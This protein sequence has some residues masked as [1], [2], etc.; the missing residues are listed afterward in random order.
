MNWVDAFFFIRVIKQALRSSG[1]NAKEKHVVDISKCA[2]FLLEAAKKCDAVFGVTQKSTLHTVRDS[3]ADIKKM[4]QHLLEKGVTKEN[5]TPASLDRTFIDPTESGLATLT[6]GEW[7]QKQ[8]QSKY[9][10]G[11]DNLE[12][13]QSLDELDLSDLDY[14]LADT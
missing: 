10:I 2:L 3:K 13:E 4:Q 1:A 11:E 8:L 12:N 6:K 14:E 9:E 5:T 7:L